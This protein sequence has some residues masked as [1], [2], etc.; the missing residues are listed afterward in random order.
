MSNQ[1]MVVLSPGI[2][3]TVQ[4]RGR[5]GL[6]AQGFSPSGSMDQRSAFIA[7][8]LVGNGA[9]C[10]VLEYAYL[11]PTLR[12]EQ[13][14][15]LAL[16]GAPFEV[17]AD[18]ETLEPYRAHRVSA[19]SILCIGRAQAGVYGYLALQGGIDVAPVLGSRSTSLRYGIGGYRGRRLE[20][21]DRLPLGAGVYG[22]LALQGGIDVAPVLGSRSTSLRYGIGGYR[23]RRL[24][25]GD[26]LPLGPLG[27]TGENGA[28]LAS[29]DAYFRWD[30]RTPRTI[31]VVLPD[32]TDKVP[33]RPL[34]EQVFTVDPQS[35]RM[36]LRLQAAGPLDTPHAD[37]TSEAL[38]W[39]T[40]Q[41]PSN[42]NP[43]V[44]MADRQT[45]GGY[46]KA[47]TVASVDLPRLAQCRP[48]TSVRFEPI[49]VAAAQELLRQDANYLVRLTSKFTSHSI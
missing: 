1:A 37:L 10:A 40:I 25:T 15:L 2:C 41:I 8:A 33:W 35:D 20:T 17:T 13:D 42:G 31:R 21:G 46:F 23:G 43:I 30:A 11:G 3:T 34:F 32:P 28:H 47:G 12:F 27:A 19:G 24:E 36:G 7:N 38:A 16:A 48:G 44:A 5:R 9:N 14:T 26:R 39:G 6:L 45:T 49:G 18:G 22:Y 4:D 29:H